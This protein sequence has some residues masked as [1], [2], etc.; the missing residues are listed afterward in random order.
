MAVIYPGEGYFLLEDS[1]MLLVILI[2]ILTGFAASSKAVTMEAF[3]RGKGLPPGVGKARCTFWG[4]GGLLWSAVTSQ[5]GLEE[6]QSLGPAI[7]SSWSL[8]ADYPSY[9]YQE[10]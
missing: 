8:P 5:L 6:A 2:T 3:A 7:T 4:F 9:R 1:F 10:P